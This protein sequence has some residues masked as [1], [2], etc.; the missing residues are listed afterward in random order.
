M[1]CKGVIG[2][3][4]VFVLSASLAAQ[5]VSIHPLGMSPRQVSADAND[6]FDRAY[7]GLLNVGVETKMY[8]KGTRT[9]A[10][11]EAPT[12]MVVQKPDG[13]TADIL[14]TQNL[15]DYSQAAAFIPDVIGTYKIAFS[16]GVQLTL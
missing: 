4:L 3:L 10:V 16:D 7:N 8:F 13:S 11:L 12:W 2:L 5:T 15:D 9:D 6:I 1:R 14:A